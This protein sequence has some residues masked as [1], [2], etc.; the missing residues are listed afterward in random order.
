LRRLFLVV[1]SIALVS[2]I[3]A[4]AFAESASENQY[5]SAAHDQYQPPLTGIGGEAANTALKASKAFSSGPGTGG[6]VV[7]PAVSEAEGEP[8]ENPTA[9]DE[10]RPHITELPETGGVS[11]LWPGVVLVAGGLVVR[12]VARRDRDR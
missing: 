4:P 11:P 8:T 7:P 3:S 12:G 1:L 10:G 5:E 2:L 6:A 9:N